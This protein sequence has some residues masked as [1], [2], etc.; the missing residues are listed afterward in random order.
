MK[1]IIFIFLFLLFF[2]NATLADLRLRELK[3]AENAILWERI[4][5]STKEGREACGS[6]S[7]A[8]KDSDAELGLAYI[9]VSN[10]RASLASLSKI[11]QY[12][13]DAS[14]SESYTCYLLNK[15]KR[16]KPFLKN[17]NPKQL[18][19][20]CIKEVLF[21]KKTNAPRFSDLNIKYI[22]ANESNIQWRIDDT[23]KGINK[24]VKCT[25]E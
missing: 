25:D 3:V 5:S 2:S 10:D 11:M 16:I 14:L 7:F 20:D 6:S 4:S 22:C 8:C 18:V 19:D 23:I 1:P 9:A 17:L 12:K 13:I 21:I 15:G 24:S